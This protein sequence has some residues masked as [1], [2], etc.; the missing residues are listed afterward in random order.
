MV[1]K[2]PQFFGCLNGL[3]WTFRAFVVIPAV[4]WRIIPVTKW[5]GLPPFY[6]PWISAG[7]LGVPGYNQPDP[8][9]GPKK[10]RKP[11]A[12]KNH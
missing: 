7:R 12:N 11:W 10:K 5:L 1:T 6:T 4:T 2:F 3:C 9:R 8:E